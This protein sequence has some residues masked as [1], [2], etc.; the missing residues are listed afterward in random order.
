[1]L[2]CLQCRLLSLA[3]F[4]LW[5]LSPASRGGTRQ[6]AACYEPHSGCLLWGNCSL[7]LLLLL[8]LLW[9]S[10]TDA[11]AV[12]VGIGISVVVIVVIWL[13]H[14][15]LQLLGLIYDSRLKH[16]ALILFK[17][18]LTTATTTT[19]TTNQNGN[20]CIARRSV[21]LSL[22]LARSIVSCGKWQA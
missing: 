9:A 2:L 14:I 7:L 17:L 18:R 19:T 20:C 4:R 16:L 12:V 5:H 10:A 6:T 22:S 21:S 15:L 1:M 8:L 11:A 13:P 3:K